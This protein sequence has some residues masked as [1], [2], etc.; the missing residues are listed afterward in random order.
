VIFASSRALV[1]FSPVFVLGFLSFWFSWLQP[2]LQFVICLCIY[3]AFLTLIDLNHSA[4]LADLAL[5]EEER[6]RLNGYSSFFSA[7]G[8]TSVFIS[9]YFWDKEFILTFQMFCVCLAVFSLI[10][11][12]I[13]TSMMK[14]YFEK[15]SSSV[16][17]S[18]SDR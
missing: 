7:I 13:S 6:T 1:K 10:G 8:S 5:S 9:Y 18:A 17:A 3:D 4:L 2:S 15:T 16:L 14:H 11:F 12:V